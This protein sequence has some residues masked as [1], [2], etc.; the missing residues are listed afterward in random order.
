MSLPGIE[1]AQ[2]L[3]RLNVHA[4]QLHAESEETVAQLEQ[5]ILEAR[6]LRAKARQTIRDAQCLISSDLGQIPQRRELPAP[7][8][9]IQ[10][11]AD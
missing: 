2:D 1:L 10:S 5:L 4:S 6:V 11:P 7:G 9:P 8:L 3:R